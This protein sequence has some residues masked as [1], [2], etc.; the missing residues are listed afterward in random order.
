MQVRATRLS[1]KNSKGRR[2]HIESAD[3]DDNIHDAIDRWINQ[4]RMPLEDVNVTQVT[5]RFEFLELGDRKPGPETF[6]VTYPNTCNL[7]GLAAE[8]VAVIEKYLRR[9]KID[10]KLVSFPY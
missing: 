6:N 3:D 2:E 5:F 8:R 7:K 4:Q 10:V 9:W 1:A